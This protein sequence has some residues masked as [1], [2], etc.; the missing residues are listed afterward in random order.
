MLNMHTCTHS[1][2][3]SLLLHLRTVDWC[4]QANHFA[5]LGQY[6]LQLVEEVLAVTA[7]G[8]VYLKLSPLSFDTH[9]E[10]GDVRTTDVVMLH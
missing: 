10:K 1:R 9:P 8:P 5:Y 3:A 6:S 2:K 7:G 4:E